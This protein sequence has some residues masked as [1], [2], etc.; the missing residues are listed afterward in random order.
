MHHS[1]KTFGLLL[2][3]LLAVCLFG[4]IAQ[5][6]YGGSGLAASAETSTYVFVPDQSKLV[7]TGGI[8]GLHW[9]YSVKGQFQLTVDPNAG[10]ASFAHVDANATDD[11]PFKRTLDLNHVFNMMS[12]V[13]TVEPTGSLKFTGKASDDS[14]VDITVTL[15]DNLAHLIGQ[16]TP[17]PN[18][19]DFFIFSLDA[20]AQFRK[21]GGGSGTA[22]DPYQIATAADLILLGESPEDYD[23]HFILTDD[24]DLGGKVFDKAVIAPDT[25]LT[26]FEFQ[27]V[28]FT[29]VLDG[30]HHMILNFNCTSPDRDYVGLFGYVSGE[31]VQIKDLGLI[32]PNVDAGTGRWIGSLVGEVRHGTISGCYAQGVSVKGKWHAGMLMGGNYGLVVA[33]HSM[34]RVSGDYVVGG[35][36]AYNGARVTDCYSTGYVSGILP[37]GGLVGANYGGCS[38]VNCYSHSIV[39]GTGF[40]IGG[41]VG[42][43]DGNIFNCYSIGNVFGGDASFDSAGGLVGDNSGQITNCYSASLVTGMGDYVGGLVGKDFSCDWDCSYGR[44]VNSFWDTQTSGQATSAGGTGKT[45]AEMQT[46]KTFLEAGWDFVNVW[47]IGENQTYPYLRKYSAADINQ[48]ASVNFLDLAVLAENWLT[49]ISH[50]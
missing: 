16:T 12:L 36:I 4:H 30:N 22:D 46:A 45:T 49:D 44:T 2:S 47:G 37:V 27:G 18:S 9:T 23:K 3:L 11:S 48:D 6:K 38:I 31:N 28:P 35:L 13:G 7:Q 21:Y 33:C 24:I 5:A 34:G 29:G 19:A 15:Q 8:A 20:V 42:D 25:D 39:N 41:L 32:D 1:S 43:N 26:K 14:D 50:R 17:P 40:F 10:T